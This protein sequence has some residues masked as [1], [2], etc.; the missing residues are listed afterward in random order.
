MFLPCTE[1]N[2][3]IGYGPS[4]T[5]NICT[6]RPSVSTTDLINNI[7]APFANTSAFVLDPNSDAILPRGAIVELC[8][9]GEK[10]FR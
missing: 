1:A 5:T 6:V 9:G 3:S 8:F 2:K 10:V 7:G 4:E